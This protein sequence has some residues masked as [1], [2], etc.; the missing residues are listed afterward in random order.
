[1]YER[2]RRKIHLNSISFTWLQYG[3]QLTVNKSENFKLV[4]LVKTSQPSRLWGES[5]LHRPVI[6]HCRRHI[7]NQL[8]GWAVHSNY[9]PLHSHVMPWTASLCFQESVL[10]YGV[11]VPCI[12]HVESEFNWQVFVRCLTQSGTVKLFSFLYNDAVSYCGYGAGDR[13]MS[14]E[15]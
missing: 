11:L 1:M 7:S 5:C 12:Y 4:T 2:L 15:H 9:T 6:T 3:L 8:A 14:V 13:W 10:S